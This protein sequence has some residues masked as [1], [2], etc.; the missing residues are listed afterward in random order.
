MCVRCSRE[1][2][3]LAGLFSTAVEAAEEVAFL[4][5]GSARS[6]RRL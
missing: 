3:T 4:D 1:N 2:T 6:S 5:A